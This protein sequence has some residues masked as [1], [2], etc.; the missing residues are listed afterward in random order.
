MNKTNLLSGILTVGSM[1]VAGVAI[2]KAKQHASCEDYAWKCHNEVM[3]DLD[4]TRK[5]LEKS[6][7]QVDKL[8]KT[9]EGWIELYE[10]QKQATETLQ[11][12]CDKWAE[13]CREQRQEIRDLREEL[14]QELVNNNK[15]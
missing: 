5:D 9:C 4:I 6:C 7:G 1:V 11:Q 12:T 8:I 15:F 13:L 2:R 10:D 3:Y 14:T